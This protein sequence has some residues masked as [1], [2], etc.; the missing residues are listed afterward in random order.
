MLFR[1]VFG[2]GGDRN[3]NSTPSLE[4]T[5][6]EENGIELVWNLGG[7][8]SNSSSWILN[9]YRDWHFESTERVWGHYKVI[10]Q[11]VNK[12]VKL[13]VLNPKS[14]ISLQKHNHRSEHWV[15]VEGTATAIIQTDKCKTE[16]IVSHNESVFVPVGAIHQLKNEQLTELK[17]IEVQ[18]GDYVGEDDIIR[19]S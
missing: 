9:R 16:Q 4:Q 18:I 3:P 5:F 11:D 8:K 19:Y 6:C 10:Y 2:N 15:V 14:S 1:F 17:I 7:D 13:I 12:K